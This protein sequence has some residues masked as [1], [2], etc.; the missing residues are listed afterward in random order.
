MPCSLPLSQVSATLCP[1]HFAGTD[2]GRV[3]AQ[4]NAGADGYKLSVNDFLVKASAL[5]LR[6]VPEANSSWMD[7]AIRRYSSV[8]INV[9]VNTEDGLFTP[10]VAHADRQ[11]LRGISSTVR[12]LADKAHA[13][14]LTPSD[15]EVRRLDCRLSL[16]LP[17]SL[18]AK[19]AA[20][21]ALPPPRCHTPPSRY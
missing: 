2:G 8:H 16:S 20:P 13:K 17:F 11:G 10:L 5:A 6:E 7:T 3:R 4:L 1:Y 9:A 18:S 14:A 12:A 21:A 15:L 19:A